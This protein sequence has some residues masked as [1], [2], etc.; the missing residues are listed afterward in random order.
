M[1][2]LGIGKCYWTLYGN[3]G[4]QLFRSWHMITMCLEPKQMGYS[5]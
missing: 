2:A 3:G 5:M 1:Y 4:Y